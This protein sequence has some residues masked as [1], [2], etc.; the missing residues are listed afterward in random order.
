MLSASNIKWL[1][2]SNISPPYMLFYEKEYSGLGDAQ[3]S[4][5]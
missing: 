4:F 3:R 5:A 1:W 2:T